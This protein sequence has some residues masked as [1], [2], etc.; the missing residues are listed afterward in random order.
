MIRQWSRLQM[1]DN[2]LYRSVTDSR[3]QEEFLQV[4][5]PE[6]R[7]EEAWRE[8]H[9]STAHAGPEKT[10]KQLRRWF[11]WPGMEEEVKTFHEGCVSCSLKH[12]PVATAY[13]A[14]NQGLGGEVTQGEHIYD[15]EAG[16]PWMLQGDTGLVDP[17]QPEKGGAEQ[18]I[19]KNALEK[20]VTPRQS[21][22]SPEPVSS[23]K[24]PEV[25]QYYGFCPMPGVPV[26][27]RRSTRANMGTPPVRYQ[28]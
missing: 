15:H 14:T 17:I 22:T 28:E 26:G 7:R 6:A 19:H 21:T 13:R 18:T 9:L 24:R 3:T 12:K 20:C 23:P 2:V 10:L 5:C 1:I 25:P 11:Y 8:V 16:I 27:P 4:V